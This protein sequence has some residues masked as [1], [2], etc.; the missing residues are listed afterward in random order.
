MTQLHT[1]SASEA[2]NRQRTLRIGLWQE[3][4]NIN[5]YLTWMATGVWLGSLSLEPLVRPDAGGMFHPVLA[6]RVPSLENG[7]IAPDGL[8]ITY[9]L[10]PNVCWADGE[11][12]TSLDVRATW[13]TLANPNYQVISREGF[14]FIKAIDCPGEHT[15]VLHF[16][17]PFP[18]FRV[19]FLCVY[20][21][22]I[23]RNLS[24]DFAKDPF[25]YAPLGT[26]PYQLEEWRRK[27]RLTFVAN[28]RF[29]GP[30][31]YFSRLDFLCVP[32]RS[33]MVSMLADGA[34]DLAL[35]LSVRDLPRVR[36]YANLVP[37][38]TPTSV[39][40]R[41]VFNQRHPALVDVRVRRAL[42][43]ATDKQHIVDVVLSGQT[44]VAASEL[45]GTAWAN[46]AVTP[47]RFA[48]AEAEMLLDKA[49]LTRGSDGARQKDGQR[50]SLVICATQGDSM[51]EAVEEALQQMYAAI[52]VELV[53]QN[54][55]ADRLFGN[56]ADKGV[57]VRGEFDLAMRARGMWGDPD[58]NMSICYQSRW[59]PGEHNQGM[60]ANFGGYHNEHVDAWLE[61]AQNI[62]DQQRRHVLYNRVQQSIQ[63][64]VPAMYLFNLPNVDVSRSGLR[65]FSQLPYINVWGTVWNAHEW[66]QEESLP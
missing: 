42:E 25:H 49:G 11:P 26:G 16:S 36:Q 58:P 41:V 53:I 61:E 52:G 21:E 9:H 23:M 18:P 29:R 33:S 22:H 24:T 66:T 4:D 3:P 60:G 27:E 32:D 20:P 35:Q 55:R 46:P 59:I 34:L 38:V 43:L 10:R 44:H 30:A 15:A 5:A 62:M 57:L 47:S 13:E 63:E 65:G 31:P 51:R 54:H 28:P 1:T 45:D 8:T 17:R 7:D 2:K 14:E 37:M 12:F 48:P 6:E 39:T 40:E 56:A 64:E 50:L 19:L